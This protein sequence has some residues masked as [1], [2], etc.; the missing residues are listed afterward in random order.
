MGMP[1]QS[2]FNRLV[3]N[4]EPVRRAHF[5]VTFQSP[6]GPMPQEEAVLA[7]RTALPAA[8]AIAAAPHTARNSQIP[9]PGIKSSGGPITLVFRIFTGSKLLQWWQS[10]YALVYDPD[11]DRVGLFN[12]IVGRGEVIL[13]GPDGQPAGVK[14]ILRDCW[15]TAIRMGQLDVEDAGDCADF[16]VSIEV[17]DVAYE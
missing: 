12:E 17:T 7:L 5:G 11:T 1:L 8:A 10:W 15:P 4:L 16:E 13:Y 3:P 9:I 2:P 6:V 14:T